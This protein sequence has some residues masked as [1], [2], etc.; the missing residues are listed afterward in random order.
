[1]TSVSNFMVLLLFLSLLAC[2][3][4]AYSIVLVKLRMPPIHLQLYHGS[5]GLAS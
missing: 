3:T 5:A 4:L 2:S 1:M